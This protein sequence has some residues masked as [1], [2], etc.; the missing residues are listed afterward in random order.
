MGIL[1]RFKTHQRV[2][3]TT[4]ATMLGIGSLNC[5]GPRPP[6]TP[7]PPSSGEH[8]VTVTADNKY[9]LYL[10]ALTGEGLTF[11]GRNE[12]GPVSDWQSPE[13]Y[14][15]SPKPGDYAYILAW[16]WGGKQMLI[17]QVENPDGSLNVSS[18][19]GWKCA[20]T[21]IVNPG[22]S[23]QAPPLESVATAIRLAQW[24]PPADSAPNGTS[25]W[26][27]MTALSPRRGVHLARWFWLHGFER[28]QGG[29]MCASEANPVT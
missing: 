11:V 18:R 23:G 25:P 29:A 7:E 5:S 21:E 6:S 27:S 8:K 26:G 1:K 14:S 24:A 17:A 12:V 16:D 19:T 28:Y 13:Q 22:V 9:A 20:I 4:A 15:I 2:T 3:T 10:G